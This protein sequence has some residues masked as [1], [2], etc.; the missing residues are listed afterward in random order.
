M[1]RRLAPLLAIVCVCG[2]RPPLSK[3]GGQSLLTGPWTT[4]DILRGLP[5]ARA[6][7]DVPSP[8]TFARLPR[9][10]DGHAFC[11]GL[12]VRSDHKLCRRAA[13]EGRR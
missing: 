10:P 9:N 2:E 6:D 1:S 3:K 4:P 5:S 8:R 11:I 12:T 7:P 13:L